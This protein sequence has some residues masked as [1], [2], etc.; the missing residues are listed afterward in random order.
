MMCEKYCRARQVTDGFACWVTK[1]TNTHSECVI[2]AAFSASNMVTRSGPM[3]CC[4]YIV[5]VVIYIC[6]V[7]TNM[8]HVE[9]RVRRLWAPK[10]VPITSF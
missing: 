1:A 6:D 8:R 7:D 9:I 4:T 5:Y 2:L 3:L 10:F